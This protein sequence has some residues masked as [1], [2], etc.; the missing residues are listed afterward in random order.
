MKKIITIVGLLSIC[1]TLSAKA[2]DLDKTLIMDTVKITN[3]LTSRAWDKYFATPDAD[4]LSI[5]SSVEK[6]GILAL[7]T[8]Y[9]LTN[10]AS[11]ESA[12]LKCAP[13]AGGY[14]AV[15]DKISANYSKLFL[16]QFSGVEKQKIE[17]EITN[18]VKQKE[19]QQDKFQQCL[20]DNHQVIEPK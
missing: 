2:A 7:N 18:L 11:K 9:Y 5:Y 1:F 14:S 10:G 6:M 15:S 17:S 19:T 4:K 16:E 20:L 3:D 8:H 13:L 12:S